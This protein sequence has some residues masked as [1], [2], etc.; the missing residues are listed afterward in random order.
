M[1]PGQ[2]R[3]FDADRADFVEAAAVEAHAPLQH[4][5][6]QHLFLQ[7]AD[8]ALG[9]ALAVGRL[10]GQCRQHLLLDLSHLG[11][12]LELGLDAH[13]IGQRSE[14][15]AFDHG[16]EGR[17]D[18]DGRLGQLGLSGPDGQVVDARAQLL[19]GLM[20]GLEA[21]QRFVFRDFL[22]PGFHHDDAVLA[23]GDHEV[24]P[25]LAALLERG[26]DDVSAIDQ[27][28]AHTGDGLLERHVR[29][30]EGCGGAGDG[31]HVGVVV[32][33]GRE[34]KRDDL[35]L[36]APAGREQRT[37]GPVDDAA[38]QRLFLGGLALALEEPAGNATRRVGVL[39]VV[40]GQR[41][42]VNA[43]AGAARAAGRDEHHGV[44]HADDHRAVGLLC[45]LARLDRQRPTP[46]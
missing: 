24:E 41:Q 18:S 9:L 40:D 15:Q 37:D 43:F 4:F 11:V 5:V 39:A 26:V 36:E 23:A 22:R 34:H 6:T 44:A 31:E 25:A 8:D 17:V 28:D 30:R 2:H 10:G 13:R 38:G 35:R 29:Q 14:G 7:R 32:L 20:C 45:P 16:M 42:E 27:A 33:V 12:V 46:E 1:H 21:C 3:G 19:D